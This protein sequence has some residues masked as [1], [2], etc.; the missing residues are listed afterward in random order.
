VSADSSSSFVYLD[1]A[2]TSPVHP[3]VWEA[4][5]PVALQQFGNP[6]S[7]HEIGQCAAEWLA[8]AREQ[9]LALL[10]ASTQTHQLIFTSG[11]TEGNNLVLQGVVRYWWQHHPNATTPPH[12]VVAATEHSAVLAVVQA[13]EASGLIQLT[14]L[15]P[16]VQNEGQFTA[17]QVVA[18]L[19]PQT[20]LVAIMHANNE[21]GVLQPIQALV[22]AVKQINPTLLFLCDMVQTIG[23]LPIHLPTLGVDFAVASGHKFQALKGSGFLVCSVAG[24]SALAPLVYGGSQEWGL[25]P[26]TVSVPHAVG[27]ATALQLK[28]STMPQALQHLTQ[29]TQWLITQL[30]TQ[31]GEQCHINTPSHAENRLAGVVNVSF[32]AFLGEKLVLKLDLRGIGVSSGSACHAGSSA[33]LPSHVLLGMG[34]PVEIAQSSIRV[35]MGATTT[36]AHLEQFLLALGIILQ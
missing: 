28:C 9:L 35:S 10:G 30:T 12:M 13:L 29:L 31:F 21:T 22:Q 33:V 8:E 2:A 20:I 27:L 19:T 17:E 25:R 11:G 3:L 36:Q 15:Y 16:F 5:Q 7:Q 34:L 1:Y 23:K 4:M 18:A 32:P 14:L 6:A 26:G 24:Q